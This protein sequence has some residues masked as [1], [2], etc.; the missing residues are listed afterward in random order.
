LEKQIN[1]ARQG[2]ISSLLHLSKKTNA[3][4][5]KI[6]QKGVFALPGFKNQR[7]H[8]HKLYEELCLVIATQKADV[9]EKLSH[10]RKGK[11]LI[12]SYRSNI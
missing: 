7:D 4:V 10:V 8:L 3:L 9:T 11:R 6:V 2:N 5:E 1:L 12:G